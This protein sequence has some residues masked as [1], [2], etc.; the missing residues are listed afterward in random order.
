M[1]NIRS[2]IKFSMILLIIAAAAYL[3]FLLLIP[4]DHLVSS[5]GSQDTEVLVPEVPAEEATEIPSPEKSKQ[6]VS[7]RT[8]A[9]MF[10]RSFNRA[11]VETV[12]I[13]E[14]QPTVRYDE[15]RFSYLGTASTSDTPQYLLKDNQLDFIF[16]ISEGE[17]VNN[18]TIT[19]LNLQEQYLIL[20]DTE[21]SFRIRIK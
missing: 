4:P 19:E 1:M 16:P 2:I 14:P 12:V 17:T 9:R 15:T 8:L 20:S 11:P 3:A 18:L 5:S 7:G 21:S 10:Y 6:A 13:V